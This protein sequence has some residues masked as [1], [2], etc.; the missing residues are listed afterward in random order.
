MLELYYAR[1]LLLIGFFRKS[2]SK[3]QKVTLQNYIESSG[4]SLKCGAEALRHA[5]F[6]GKRSCTCT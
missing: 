2:F 3:Q 6:L 1:C 5:T 4:V